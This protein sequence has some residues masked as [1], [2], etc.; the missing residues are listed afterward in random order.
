MTRRQAVHAY[1]VVR[2][3]VA[4]DAPNHRGRASHL[5][6]IGGGGRSDPIVFFFFFESFQVVQMTPFHH[7]LAT[8]P[9]RG[10]VSP[11]LRL[12]QSTEHDKSIQQ[13]KKKNLGLTRWPP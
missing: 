1:E 12:W 3:K 2:C 13:K 10:W 8:P 4:P 11:S 7:R 5:S 6:A 9:V